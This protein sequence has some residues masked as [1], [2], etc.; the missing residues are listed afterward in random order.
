MKLAELRSDFHL[1]I[2]KIE[3]PEILEQF[4][5]A[6]SNSVKP[7]NSL[8]ATLTLE[9]QKGVLEAYEESEDED[10]LVPLSV[11]KSKFK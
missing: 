6:L 2:D 1:L 11:I 8:W 10:N 5:D 3:D 7:N 4:Y 9:Q